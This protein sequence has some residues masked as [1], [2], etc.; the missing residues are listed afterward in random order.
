MGFLSI[1]G[2]FSKLSMGT[3][4]MSTT[5]QAYRLG[6]RLSLGRLFGFYYAHIGSYLGQLHY[7]HVRAGAARALGKA[8]CS[9]PRPATA[10][11]TAAPRRRYPPPRN[12]SRL[13]GFPRRPFYRCRWPT[14]S[15]RSR[16]S[17]RSPR[18]QASSRGWHTRPR[19][20]STRSVAGSL[21]FS[22]RAACCRS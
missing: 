3:A 18:A 6:T 15:S 5:R 17:A 11:R 16:S 22:S 20:Y 10:R 1:L 8:S 13:D 19:R 14:C 21:S 2:F 9:V 12:R 4:Q 7:Y